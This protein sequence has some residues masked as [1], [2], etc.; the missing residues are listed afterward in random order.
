MKSRKRQIERKMTKNDRS[1]LH[2]VLIGITIHENTEECR[3]NAFFMLD[4]KGKSVYKC[5]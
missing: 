4:N 2:N 3:K 1:N 5:M